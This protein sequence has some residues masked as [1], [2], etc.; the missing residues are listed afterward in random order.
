MTAPQTTDRALADAIQHATAV[1]RRL[2]HRLNAAADMTAEVAAE[3]TRE[4]ALVYRR[5][6]LD[7]DSAAEHNNRIWFAIYQAAEGASHAE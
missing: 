1:A 4:T 7:Q 5:A 6:G 2:R 3:Y